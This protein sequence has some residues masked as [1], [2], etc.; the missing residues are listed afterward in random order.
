MKLPENNHAFIDG[1]NLHL[2]MGNVGWLLNY[3]RFRVYLREKYHVTEAYYFIGKVSGNEDLYSNLETW[4]YQTV[5]KP[6]LYRKGEGYKGNCDAE[7]VLKVMI[8]LKNNKFDSAVIVTSDGDFSCLVEYL[9]EENK[10]KCVLAPCKEG[11]SRLLRKAA[12]SK[13]DYMDNLKGKLEYKKELKGEE[14]PRKDE[15]L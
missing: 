14:A 6:T 13:I 4:G 11:C 2:T 7:L 10:L 3:Q 12:R 15:T 5:F 1:T 8:D 9:N